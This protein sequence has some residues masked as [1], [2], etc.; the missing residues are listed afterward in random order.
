MAKVQTIYEQD[1]SP[2]NIWGKVVIYLREHHFVALH[3]AC[4]DISDVKIENECFNI[5]INEDM[6]YELLQNPTNMQ[7]LKNAF[8]SYGISKFQVIKKDKL[9]SKSQEDLKVL[10]Q[11]FGNKLIIE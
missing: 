6:L 1:N 3:I 2:R 7:A 9:L 8:E 10:K 11:I 5:Y 4:G